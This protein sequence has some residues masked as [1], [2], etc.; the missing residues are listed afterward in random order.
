MSSKKLLALFNNLLLYSELHFQLFTRQI[1]SSANFN[2]LISKNSYV[3][4][5]LEGRILNNEEELYILSEHFK[6]RV[7]SLFHCAV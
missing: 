4:K 6:E 5:I 2:L 3:S 1:L 7:R